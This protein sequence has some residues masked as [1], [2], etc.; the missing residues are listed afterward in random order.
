VAELAG[1]AAD[2]Y[3]LPEAEVTT[4]RRA[5]LVHD[6]GRLG[7]PNTIW[8]KPA[9]LSHAEMERVRLHPY[10]MERMLASSR[11]L[12]PL[13][14]LAAQHHERLDGS[15]YRRGLRG[16]A[17]SPGARI[18]A[19]ADVYHALVEPRPHRPALAPDRAVKELRQ[20]VKSRRLDGAAVDAVLASAG[21]RIRRRREWPA[22]LTAREVEVLRLV[23]LGL[24]N[25]EMAERLVVSKKTVASHIEHIYGKIGV[26]TR[27]AAALFASEH[28]LLFKTPSS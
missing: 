6:L 19:A 25:R 13:G 5:A 27:A 21:H 20:E 2:R 16:S 14:E 3:Q 10:Y 1:A 4:I 24:T 8:D 26:S 18:L 22:G 17:L 15:G 7:I 11:A 28:G 12:A 9:P 23:A